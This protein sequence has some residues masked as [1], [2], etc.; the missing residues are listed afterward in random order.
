MGFMDRIQFDKDIRNGQPC[1]KGT[2]IAVSD[3]LEYLGSGMSEA[4]ILADFSDL[5][6]EDIRA[7][8]LFGAD[9][10]IQSARLFGFQY[11][12]DN[13]STEAYLKQ[14]LNSLRKISDFREDDPLLEEPGK[15]L[16]RTKRLDELSKLI[17]KL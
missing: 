10:V 17:A 13:S 1:I 15:A 2:R 9:L 5:T 4:E 6:E 7:A 3:I 11:A 16:V 14:M 12:P 8:Q